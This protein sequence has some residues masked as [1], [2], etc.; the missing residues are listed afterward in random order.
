MKP[1][2]FLDKPELLKHLGEKPK[3]LV[4]E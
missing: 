2:Y 3:T 1:T 4:R